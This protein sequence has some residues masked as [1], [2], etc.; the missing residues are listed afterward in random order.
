MEHSDKVFAGS[1]PALYDEYLVPLIFQPYA[2][3]LARRLKARRMSKLLEIAAG[4]GSLSAGEA[5]LTLVATAP[6]RASLTVIQDVLGRHLERFGQR[7][8]LVVTWNED[9]G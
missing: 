3:D 8:G 4:T 9:L 2:D 5:V 7:D 6:D 1:I